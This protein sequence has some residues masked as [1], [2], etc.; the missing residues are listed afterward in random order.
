MGPEIAIIGGGMGELGVAAL[1][2]QFS[3]RSTVYEQAPAYEDGVGGAF[4]LYPNGLKVIRDVGGVELLRDVLTGAEPYQFRR[5]MRHDG[6]EVAVAS[7]EALAQGDLQSVGIRRWRLQRAILRAVE[8]EGGIKIVMGKKLKSLQ[9]VEGDVSGPVT[10]LFED[11]SKVR[12]DFVFGCDGAKS[13]T[14]EN[15]CG[16]LEPVYGGITC[17]MG[18]ADMPRS[19]PGI[20]FPTGPN[21]RHGV[22]YPVGPNEQVFQIYTVT[23]MNPES[24]KALTPAEAEVEKRQLCASLRE[25]GWSEEFVKPVE[26]GKN[27]IRVG[28][29]DR[30]PV[31]KW[32]KGRVVLVGD[33]AHP[34]APYFGQGAMMS[35]EDVGTFALCAKMMGGADVFKSNLS[36]FHHVC[37]KYQKHRF[38]RA[39]NTLLT[40]RELGRM[41]LTRTEGK[42]AGLAREL[43]LW[44]S[45]ALFGTLPNLK[46]G[47]EYD[48]KTEVARTEG[49]DLSSAMKT[50]QPQAAKL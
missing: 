42:V 5:W 31:E 11:G 28:I 6:T 22:W 23:P 47:A 30:A 7:E 34:V 3:L 50:R 35:F 19:K 27:I 10:I 9:N 16:V 17:L 21:R 29:R 1:K 12:A 4:G 14:R 15:I 2:K 25:D 33:A 37:E 40:S 26:E 43:Q 13:R 49:W 18:S 38:P 41:Q 32:F 36:S 24:W 46:K 39:L 20:C 44:V 45:V 8:R 48:F